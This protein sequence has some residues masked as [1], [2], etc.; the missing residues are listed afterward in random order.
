M[1]ICKRLK[2]GFNI[3]TAFNT[4]V[5]PL[6][7]LG[8]SLFSENIN[9]QTGKAES[10]KQVQLE[11]FDGKKFAQDYFNAWSATQKPEATKK[12]IE[13]Y[14]SFYKDDLGHQHLP[15]SPDDKRYPDGKDGMR[16]GM[17]HYLG[18]HIEYR[19]K[20][21]NSTFGHQ[22]IVIEYETYAKGQRP[23]GETV[24]QEYHTLEVLE[25]EDN[26][27]SVIRKYSN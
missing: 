15:Y 12:D 16:E 26:K 14:L 27:I 3:K 4:T 23:G 17:T 25:I 20:L 21:I 8:F 7:L 18:A 6:I 22:V 19:S 9:A 5:I 13:H 2:L 11:K 1:L 24:V 10:E